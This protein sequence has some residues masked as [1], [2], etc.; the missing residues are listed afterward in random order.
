MADDPELA[1]LT[2]RFDPMPGSEQPLMGILAEYVV[3]TRQVAECRNIDLLASASL[4]GRLLLVE[5][6]ESPGAAR[7]HLDSPEMAEMAAAAVGHLA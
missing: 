2:A 6:W 1:V 7:A 3:V 5:K 4:P